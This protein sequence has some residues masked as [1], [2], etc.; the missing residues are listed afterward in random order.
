MT[1]KEMLDRL[2]ELI[3]KVPL[4]RRADV[5]VKSE[6]INLRISLADKQGIERMAAGCGLTVTEYLTR[7]HYLA[8]Q[9]LVK[10]STARAA[11]PRSRGKD[12]VRVKGHGR[13]P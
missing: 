7:L 8:E 13:K 12:Q 2:A 11:A 6:R 4:Q 3:K 9:G 5:L 1:Q 10:L